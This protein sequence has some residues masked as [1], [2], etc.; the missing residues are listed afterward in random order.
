MSLIHL[1]PEYLDEIN[2]FIPRQNNKITQILGSNISNN[3]KYDK[4]NNIINK[5]VNKNKKYNNLWFINNKDNDNIMFLSIY[6]GYCINN[7]DDKL[8]SFFTDKKILDSCYK[9]L[10]KNRKFKMSYK[11]FI[12]NLYYHTLIYINFNYD[13]DKIYLIFEFIKNKTNMLYILRNKIN[14]YQLF[15]ELD[16][17]TQTQSDL[18]NYNDNLYI[19]NKKLVKYSSLLSTILFKYQKG[20]CNE[21]VLHNFYYMLKILNENNCIKDYPLNVFLFYNFEFLNHFE[22][23]QYAIGIL[24][25]IY[26]NKE[27]NL[28]L[29]EDVSEEDYG[30]VDNNELKNIVRNY[31]LSRTKKYKE[32]KKNKDLY[33][34]DE[35]CITYEKFKDDDT[36]FLGMCPHYYIC[37]IH[38]MDSLVDMFIRN[39]K[40]FCPMCKDPIFDLDLDLHLQ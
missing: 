17:M 2:Y 1:K 12:T 37:N 25:T 6:L 35:C 28:Y 3:I 13:I 21:F 27:N 33:H 14:I 5:F 7:Q 29:F 26:E 22:T 11:L 20:H 4:I 38:N 23:K 16:E 15:C 8:W 39:G 32:I 19:Y 10:N 36:V 24:S 9:S 34:Q 30:S 40:V 18:D 31:I